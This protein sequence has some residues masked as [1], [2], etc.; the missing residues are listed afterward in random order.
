MFT[1]TDLQQIKTHNL[2]PE[3]VN[4]QINQIKTGMIFSDLVKAAT[5]GHGILKFTP[6]QEQYYINS[7]N[8][9]KENKSI[10]KFVPASGAATRMFKFLFQF[11]KD[12]ENP[13]DRIDVYLRDH[14]SFWVFA[15]GVERMPFHDL[16]IEKSI[17]I[18]PDYKKRSYQDRFI[19]FVKTMLDTDKLNYTFYPKGLLPFHKYGNN[20]VTAFREHLLEATM[21]ASVK[22]GANLHFTISEV[23]KNM[24]ENELNTVKSKLESDTETKF[25]VSFSYQ[26]KATDT[27]AITANNELYRTPEGRLLF[28]PSGHGALIENLNALNYDL[29]FIKNIDNIVI[30]KRNKAVSEYKKMLAGVLLDIQKKAFKFLYDLEEEYV[31][32]TKIL[33]IAAFISAQMNVVLHPDFEDFNTNK[34]TKYLYNVLNRPIRV[35]GMVKNE[36]EPGGGPFWVKDESG[37]ISLQIIEF[38]QINTDK[39]AQNTIVDKATHFNPTDLVCGIKNY[40]GEKFNLLDFVD[41]KA[42]FITMKSQN[43]TDIKALERPGLW[44]G[45]MAYWNSIFVEIPLSTFNPV[46]TVNDLLKPAH[47]IYND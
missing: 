7:Y 4:T 27:I 3:K 44:N 23:H 47:Q 40:K 13:K 32:E 5:I 43:G 21:Y 38:A 8:T 26:K 16:V 18:N 29:I 33:E 42:A 28:R 2:T 1:K 31:P 45:S 24:F 6:K 10:V 35:C 20:V 11:L 17:S 15:N 41:E 19:A 36:G 30:Y 12:F 22:G 14:K 37:N 25:S 9:E 34:K 46:K 39:E